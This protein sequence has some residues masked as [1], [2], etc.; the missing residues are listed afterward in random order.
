MNEET[1]TN[2]GWETISE[3]L[4]ANGEW[5]KQW[6]ALGPWRDTEADAQADVPTAPIRISTPTQPL[7][8]AGVGAI[9]DMLAMLRMKDERIAQL[10]SESNCSACGGELTCRKDCERQL[11]KKDARIAELETADMARL[12]TV[13]EALGSELLEA[14]DG[15]ED[16]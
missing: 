3:W 5:I 6:R 2:D 16:A 12:E 11:A 1:K 14:V 13:R 15:Y 10:E 9:S 8:N 7:M 4:S